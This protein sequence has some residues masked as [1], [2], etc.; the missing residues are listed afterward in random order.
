MF[1]PALLLS[2]GNAGLSIDSARIGVGVCHHMATLHFTCVHRA[3]APHDDGE[4]QLRSSVSQSLTTST[5]PSTDCKIDIFHCDYDENHR[6]YRPISPLSL[7]F[8]L[9][10]PAVLVISPFMRPTLLDWL[11]RSVRAASSAPSYPHRAVRLLPRIDIFP[12]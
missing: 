8:D 1:G 11:R 9:F 5:I 6:E 4:D 7:T 2:G 3:E 10:A 12:R